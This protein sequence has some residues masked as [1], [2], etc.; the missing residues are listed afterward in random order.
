MGRV[1]ESEMKIPWGQHSGS[2]WLDPG[3]SAG[4]GLK[5]CCVHVD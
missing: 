3:G 5:E 4:F 1:M 2:A